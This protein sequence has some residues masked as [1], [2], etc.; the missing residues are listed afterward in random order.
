MVRAPRLR[1]ERGNCPKIVLGDY[2]GPFNSERGARNAAVV[3][4]S[5]RIIA[6]KY[7]MAPATAWKE[8]LNG[9]RTAPSLR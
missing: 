8:I 5:R 1:S 7:E 6:D 4:Y 3:D 9:K 2:C